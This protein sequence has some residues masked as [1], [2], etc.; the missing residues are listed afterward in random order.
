MKKIKINFCKY[1]PDDKCSYSYYILN[2][3]KKY[4]EVEISKNPDYLFYNESDY[5]HLNYDCVKIFYTGENIHPNFNFCDY[6]FGFDHISFGDRYCRLPVYFVSN[7]Y[8][9]EEIE[10]IKNKDIFTQTKFTIEDLKDKTDFCS[11]VYSNY[12][13][14]NTR[15]IFFDKLSSYKRVNSGGAYLNNVG[16]RIENKLKFEMKHKFSIAFENSSNIGYTTEKIVNSFASNTIPI[17]WGNP[18]IGKEFNENRFVNCHSYKNFDE[19][20]KKIM[21]IDNDGNLYLNIIN[22]PITL[23]DLKETEGNFIIF[24]K[25]I[26]EQPIDSVKRVSI[27][28][29]ISNNLEK[30]EVMISKHLN[31][32]NY[33]RKIVA[34][35]YKPFKKIKYIEN[36][37]HDYL[38]NQLK[39]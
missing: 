32:K 21:E 22:A 2:I 33:L 29:A 11:F 9:K 4:Y 31:S 13:A 25:N 15:K 12:L 35:I 34:Y 18:E 16:G 19:V 10:M 38:S 17:Y 20:I 30:N 39:K 1:N 14:D 36:F 28:T 37:K 23:I 5:E 24:L 27:N 7:F 26:F 3:L 8:R 6:A